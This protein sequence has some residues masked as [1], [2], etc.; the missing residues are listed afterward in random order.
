MIYRLFPYTLLL[1]PFLWLLVACDSKRQEVVTP[2][3]T[4]LQ[5][6]SVENETVFTYDDILNNGE[7]I[8]LT[9]SGP[10]TYY[11][12]H[13]RPFGWQY[14]LCEQFAKNVGVSLRVDVC[15]DTTE[16][17]DKLRKGE[18]DLVMLLLPSS[19]RGVRFTKIGEPEV[20][21]GKI[22][23]H[24]AVRQGND[25]LCEALDNW[26]KPDMV[27]RVK[28]EERFA[29]SVRSVQRHTYSPMLN[30]AGGVISPYDAH[31]KKYA[32]LAGCDWRLMAAQCYQESTFDPQARSWAGACGLMQIMPSTARYLGLPEHLLFHPE[33]NIAAAA[34]YLR[35]LNNKFADVPN[36]L[37]RINFVLAAYNGGPHH[38]RDAMALARKQG[39]NSKLW[40]E[41]EPFVLGLSRAEYYTDPVVKYG[42]MRGSETVNY[43]ARIRDRW[44]S[45]RHVIP[46]M[47]MPGVPA[48]AKRKHRFR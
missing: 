7:M 37:E 25:A 35:E 44:N 6:D 9:L 32:S 17:L 45:Y 8:A 29:L 43:V 40:H 15:R 5:S 10:D 39:K 19:I 33:E 20:K 21:T 11:D 48:P 22:N 36:R 41:V 34:R 27:A 23:L 38:I 42:Y 28:S 31:F 24:W 13:G 26:F 47:D 12:Y 4:T 30:A 14:L 18:G 3:G 1:L 2:W 16:L 46:G